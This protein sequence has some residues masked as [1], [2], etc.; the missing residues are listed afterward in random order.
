MKEKGTSR[1]AWIAA[2][3]V[4][5]IAFAAEASVPKVEVTVQAHKEVVRVD[6]SGKKAVEL[7]PADE[8]AA[9]DT[10]VYTLRASN[11]G[12]GPALNPRIED[13][14]PAGTVLVVDSVAKDGAAIEASLDGG[15]TWQPFPAMV[16]RKNPK[17]VDERVEAPAEIY[18]TLRW[19]LNGPLQPGDGKDVSFKVRIR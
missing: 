4:I 13:P 18:T 7:K 5:G 19:V 9:G 17:G 6:A 1:T 14:I 3:A 15:K 2:L 8:A 12:T 10:I 11:T 16:T